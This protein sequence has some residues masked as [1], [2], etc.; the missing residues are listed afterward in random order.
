MIEAI[1]TF[2]LVLVGRV[3]FGGVIRIAYSIVVPLNLPEL[4]EYV[5]EL[6]FKKWVDR[7]ELHSS[8][9]NHSFIVWDCLNSPYRVGNGQVIIEISIRSPPIYDSTPWY[10]SSH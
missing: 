7:W 5:W 6:P 9:V 1:S 4:E 10:L 3:E 8:Q 2:F